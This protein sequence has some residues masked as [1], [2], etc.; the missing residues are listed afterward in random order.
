MR[1]PRSVLK[2]TL[3][4][5]ILFALGALAAYAFPF[6]LPSHVARAWGHHPLTPI[7][8][9]TFIFLLAYKPIERYVKQ[10][11]ER[12]FFHRKSFA[13]ITLMDLADELSVNLDLQELANLVVNT[14]GEVMRLK[15]VALLVPE[16]VQNHFEVASAYGWPI[17][18]SKRVRLPADAPLLK[19]VYQ[20]GP[21]TLVRGLLLQALSWQEANAL[22]RD[23]DTLRAGWVMPLF[24]KGELSGLIA[25]G[26]QSPDTLF[27]QSDFHFFR[28]FAAG[29]AKSVHNA[30]VVQR[31]RQRNLELQDFQSQRIQ[32][33][34]LNAIEKLAAGIAH[35]IH[36][37]LAIISG[38]AQVLLM[39][40]GPNKLEQNVQE[41]LSSIVKQ[42]QKAADITRKLLLYS[43]GSRGPQE[44]VCLEKVLD[45]TLALLAY[46]ASLERIEIIKQCE[47]EVPSFR[48]NIQEMR[49]VF[50]NLL[51]NAVEAVDTQGKIRIEIK[52]RR[53]EAIIEIRCADTGK[54]IPAEHADKVFD[55]FYTTR[56]EAVGLGLFV[57]RQIV[58]RYGGAIRVESQA[59]E[60]SLFII[61][62]P[63]AVERTQAQALVAREDVAVTA[64]AGQ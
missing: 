19:L 18:A 3:V 16:A 52:H 32:K 4:G 48:A 50:L 39:Q 13:Q 7:F 24:V 10:F 8:V 41:T 11:L 17:S 49:E 38:K 29:V 6:L 40:R 22:S 20:N 61:Q 35:E 47:A 43:Q 37:P 1:T 46:Q 34:K 63:C 45:E 15:T 33:T 14:F 25:F 60:G 54:G 5:L 21:H 58:H 64:K 55:P 62:L 28:Q 51:L 53:D 36:N 30:L 57:T 23:F 2:R 31:L 9:I 59:G 42:T 12:Y 44:W 56:H 27:D 26:A